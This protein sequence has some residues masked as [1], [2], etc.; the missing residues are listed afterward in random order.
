MDG[1]SL[2]LID[3]DDAGFGYR[4]YDLGTVLS[5]NQAEPH[6]PAIAEA[7]AGGYAAHRPLDPA[8]LPAMTLMRCCAS[9]GWTMPRLAPDDPIH[10]RH[11]DRML[12]LATHLLAGKP[13]WPANP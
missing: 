9:V 3:F 8:I 6:L 4:P 11:I 12:R 7:L 2:A 5:Q 1:P 10:R 13:G